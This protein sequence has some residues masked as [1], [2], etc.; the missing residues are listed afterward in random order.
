[1]INYVQSSNLALSGSRGESVKK[2]LLETFTLKTISLTN[3]FN[4]A[5]HCDIFPALLQTHA[6][7]R[8]TLDNLRLPL[9][10]IMNLGEALQHNQTLEALDLSHNPAMGCEGARALAGGIR[11]HPK[12]SELRLTACNIATEGGKA[13]KEALE[14]SQCHV[15]FCL[16]A[17]NPLEKELLLQIESAMQDKRVVPPPPSTAKRLDNLARDVFE[18]NPGEDI[19]GQLLGKVLD[20]VE[21]LPSVGEYHHEIF[22]EG[23]LYRYLVLSKLACAFFASLTL[24]HLHSFWNVSTFGP[25]ALSVLSGGAWCFASDISSCLA[26][27][28]KI[29]AQ[30]Y[31][32]TQAGPLYAK[33]VGTALSRNLRLPLAD[34]LEMGLVAMHEKSWVVLPLI[35][36]LF[37][38]A[39]FKINIINNPLAFSLEFRRHYGS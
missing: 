39:H 3:T 8:L 12:L 11:R 21:L 14:D 27:A 29:N 5:P 36:S 6:L 24:V 30:A 1:M 31:S 37:P 33:L 10:I 13:L 20:K 15:T 22:E 7:E 23:Q 16:L 17:D 32:V 26:A 18:Q 38:E 35:Q 4:F 9:E 25:F 2:H 34:A 28:L 19:A